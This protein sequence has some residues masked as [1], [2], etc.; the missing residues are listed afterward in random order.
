MTYM[1]PTSSDEKYK[2]LMHFLD[3]VE[4]ITKQRELN[5]SEYQ[6]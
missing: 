4:D 5:G 2:A 6:S 3:K 1:V